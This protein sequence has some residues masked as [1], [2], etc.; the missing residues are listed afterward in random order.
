M[1]VQ[2]GKISGLQSGA[3]SQ[4]LKLKGQIYCRSWKTVKGCR[5]GPAKSW[6]F[7]LDKRC[8]P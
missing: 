5:K 1:K 3:S 4:S 2:E 6:N 8:K 7:K